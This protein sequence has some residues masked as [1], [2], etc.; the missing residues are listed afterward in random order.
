MRLA[1]LLTV[2]SFPLSAGKLE[3]EGKFYDF[4]EIIAQTKFEHNRLKGLVYSN[5]FDG[6]TAK[7]VLTIRDVRLDPD[8]YWLTKLPQ[9]EVRFEPENNIPPFYELKIT[10]VPITPSLRGTYSFKICA[11]DANKPGL[12]YD[13]FEAFIKAFEKNRG[14]GDYSR[15]AVIEVVGKLDLSGVVQYRQFTPKGTAQIEYAFSPDKVEV[16]TKE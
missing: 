5:P 13:I 9:L 4:D 10:L 12:P 7:L 2:L 16:L 15:P 11:A 6:K 8:K 3:I 1:L 14:Q